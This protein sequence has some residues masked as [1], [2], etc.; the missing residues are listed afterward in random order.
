MED[1]QYYRIEKGLPMTLQRRYGR[2]YL[3][4]I[5]ESENNVVSLKKSYGKDKEV[6]N[7]LSRLGQDAMVLARYNAEQRAKKGISASDLIEIH[8][9][10][11][12]DS[13]S[14]LLRFVENYMSNEVIRWVSPI[15]F[16][17]DWECVKVKDAGKF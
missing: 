15:D 5:T 14:R 13:E 12:E 10:D 6:D 1:L 8:V 7:W 11:R 17:R 3:M 2:I 4:S 16:C 9:V